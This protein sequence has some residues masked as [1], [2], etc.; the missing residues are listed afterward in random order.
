MKYLRY[1]LLGP[2]LLLARATFAQ[3]PPAPTEKLIVVSPA[4]GDVIDG[5]EKS[6]FGLFLYYAADDFVEASFYQSLRPD[7][8]ITLR[9]RMRDGR[10]LA[11]PFTR[12]EFMT[13][14]ESIARRMK[15]LGETMPVAAPAAA[16]VPGA[17]ASAAAPADYPFVLGRSYR[18]ETRDGTTFSG[19]L[20]G[21]TMT[22]LDFDSPALGKVTVQ[23]VNITGV[24][25][26][27]GTS[28][29]SR[30]AGARKYYDIGNG[31]RLFFGPTARGLRQGEGTLQD[32]DVYLLGFNYGISNNFSMGGYMSIV[33]GLSLTE[34]LLVLTPKLS[35]KVRENLHTGAGLLYLR[36]PAGNGDGVGVG[37]AYGVITTGSADNNFTAGLGYGFVDNEI[38]S[39]PI[40][41]LGGQTRVSRRVS[42]LTENYIVADAEAGMGG[43]YGMKLSWRRTSLGLGALY[44]YSFPYTEDY[45]SGFRVER[46][47]RFFSTYLIP[48]YIDFT[49]RFGK[50]A[51]QPD[52]PR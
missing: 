6:R 38:G 7:S 24:Q 47:G 36:V 41:M 26:L 21:M 42:L 13:V 1:L 39:T 29:P 32:V 35:F 14:R 3:A 49:F 2:A 8:A 17:P 27:E 5:G 18:I 22:A 37:I 52:A 50:G 11:R 23:R 20:V 46:P 45:G 4:V 9:S 10:E 28:A 34:Q 40:I 16:S 31:N 15:E 44:F 25:D 12:P 51:K 43:F 30:I 19:Q 33:P 48:V